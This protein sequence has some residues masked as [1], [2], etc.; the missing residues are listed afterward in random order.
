MS[1]RGENNFALVSAISGVVASLYA[2]YYPS[3]HS[4][5]DATVQLSRLVEAGGSDPTTFLG[6]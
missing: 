3:A 2:P 6:G 5:V 4:P 1:R